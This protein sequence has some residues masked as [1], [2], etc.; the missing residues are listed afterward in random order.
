MISNACNLAHTKLDLKG[1][2][3]A[4]QNMDHIYEALNFN[5]QHFYFI[6][7]FESVLLH[8]HNIANFPP[9]CFNFKFSMLR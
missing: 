5:F 4:E 2:T 1:C 3:A 9:T 7:H 8:I 6:D